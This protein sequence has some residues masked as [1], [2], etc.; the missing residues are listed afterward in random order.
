MGRGGTRGTMTDSFEY[1]MVRIRRSDADPR[2][3]TGH[4][5]CLRTGEKRHFE[6]GEDLVRLVAAWPADEESLAQTGSASTKHP[7]T[8]G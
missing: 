4:V 8:Q 1:Y 2:Q 5:E 7:E 6:C 3:V